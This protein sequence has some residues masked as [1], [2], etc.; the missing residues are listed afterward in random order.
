MRWVLF[1]T[2]TVL[3]AADVATTYIG[4]VVVEGFY[5]A[6]PIVVA[7]AGQPPALWKM[8]VMKAVVLAFV[9]WIVY[10]SKDKPV[11]IKL[12]MGLAVILYV[13][14]VWNNIAVIL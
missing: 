2:V 11:P 3:Q 7:L 9:G 12:T 10:A 6:N 8:I 5:E 1:A 4:S 13:A 14:I